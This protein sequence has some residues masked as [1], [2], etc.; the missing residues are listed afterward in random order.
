MNQPDNILTVRQ[1]AVDFCMGRRT[2]H[3]VNDVS[4]D[5]GRGRVLG[6]V[7]ESG[8]GKS[9]TAHSVLQLLPRNGS[10][11]GGSIN[12]R[13]T[14]QE[15]LRLTSLD[16]RD[17]R[18]RAIRG[19]DIAMVFQ[20]PMSSLN[21][22]YTIG[23]QIL[24][25]LREHE[26]GL[27]RREARE[28]VIELLGSLGIPSPEKR[29][30]EY[31]HQ[32]SGGMKQRVMIAIAMV[33]R[34]RL[35]IADEPTTALDVTI[36]AQILALMKQ[37][38]A[39]QGTSIV[40]ITHNMGIVAEICDDVAV[41]YMGRVVECGTL[42]QVFSNPLHP[43]TQAL[44]RSVPVLGMDKSAKLDSIPGATPDIDTVFTGCEFAD[45]CPYAD[46]RCRGSFPHDVM[47]EPGHR[48]RCHRCQGTPWQPSEG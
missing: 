36:Q 6:I 33:C 40:L 20:D 5:V 7:G 26:K 42:E 48:V 35:L 47:A 1:L 34:P 13:P 41:M 15:C 17:R 31:P 38:Q 21:P 23:D 11:A 28:R 22:V 24:E 44:L 19:A 25:N 27:S 45:R 9:V 46:D 32:F 3:A 39:Q 30:Q 2:V 14:P 8:C 16:R 18:L 4:F 29:M 10:I 12:Y 43:Y 37:L